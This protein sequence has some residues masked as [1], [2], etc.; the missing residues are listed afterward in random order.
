MEYPTK[1]FQKEISK[2]GWGIIDF[3]FGFRG[4]NDPAE[5]EFDDLRSD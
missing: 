2:K 3:I 5:T 1:L 4:V